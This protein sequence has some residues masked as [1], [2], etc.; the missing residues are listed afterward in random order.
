M[1]L[2]TTNCS[3][4]SPRALKLKEAANYLGVSPVSIRH[5]PVFFHRSFR[6]MFIVRTI[7]KGVPV[8]V[9]AQYQ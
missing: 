7:E 2:I 6:R 1:D 3:G 5:L 4:V 9:I 8:H